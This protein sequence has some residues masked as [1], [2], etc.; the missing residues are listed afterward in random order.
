MELL[1]MEQHPMEEGLLSLVAKGG[2]KIYV[3]SMVFPV[4]G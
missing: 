4:Y 1:P 3:F 2:H